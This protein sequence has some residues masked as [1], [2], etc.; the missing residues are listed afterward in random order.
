MKTESVG[1]VF[2]PG[3]SRTAARR[4]IALPSLKAKE[5]NEYRNQWVGG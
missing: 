2:D 4:S 3:G 5:Q 1:F